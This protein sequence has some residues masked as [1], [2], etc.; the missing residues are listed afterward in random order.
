[1]FRIAVIVFLLVC[2]VA[3]PAAAYPP[4][5]P[6]RPGPGPSW[7]PIPPERHVFSVMIEAT[8]GGRVN[9][10]GRLTIIRGD[11]VMISILP[12][13]RH[14]IKSVIVD[15]YEV[16]PT[17]LFPLTNIQHDHS[18]FVEFASYES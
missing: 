3:A 10:C 8:Y 2:C 15:G 5:H 17:Y 9:P 11:T 1:M 6:P 12:D 4:H 14:F 13:R 7:P 18:V 16:G